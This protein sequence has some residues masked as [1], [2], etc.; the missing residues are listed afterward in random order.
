MRPEDVPAELVDRAYEQAHGMAPEPGHDRAAMARA[1]AAVIPAVQADE[2]AK[3]LAEVR[4]G[5]PIRDAAKEREVR[6]KVADEIERARP[7][8]TTPG[9]RHK[10]YAM[11][12][13]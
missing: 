7:C 5:V 1:L 8:S 9:P 3:I 2:R 13:T 10:H 12:L 4:V 11:G 6:A